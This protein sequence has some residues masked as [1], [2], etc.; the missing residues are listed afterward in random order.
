MVSMNGEN[1]EVQARGGREMAYATLI[2][3]GRGHKSL[4]SVKAVSDDE[5]AFL[6]AR[7]YEWNRMRRCWRKHLWEYEV[8][9][10]CRALADGGIRPSGVL[11]ARDGNDLVWDSYWI[12]EVAEH[13][14]GDEK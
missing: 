14:V 13:L 12:E 10:E 9:A 1:N 7:G 5:A 2:Q 11:A 4:L 8:Q 3:G 6:S